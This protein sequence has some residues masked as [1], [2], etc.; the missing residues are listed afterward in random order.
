MH[1]GQ[2]SNPQNV[3]IECETCNVVLLDFDHED[4]GEDDDRGDHPNDSV[5]GLGDWKEAVSMDET[6]LGYWDWVDEQRRSE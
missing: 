4:C 2:K 5:Y 6:F 1:R 3:A